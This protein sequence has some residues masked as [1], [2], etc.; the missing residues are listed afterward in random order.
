MEFLS[1]TSSR[2]KFDTDSLT[3]NAEE[4]DKEVEDR[5]RL[6]YGDVPPS[7]TGLVLNGQG[8]K[9][10]YHEPPPGKKY[11]GNAPNIPTMNRRELNS[12]IPP[13]NY[14]LHLITKGAVDHSKI[15][16]DSKVEI[17]QPK[18]I[19]KEHV[20][21]VEKIPQRA[22][23]PKDG[24]DSR[25]QTPGKL[26][27]SEVLTKNEPKG[28]GTTIQKTN[29]APSSN[30]PSPA[31]AT[32][33]SLDSSLPSTGSTP[34]KNS[35]RRTSVSNCHPTDFYSEVVPSN[36]S[37]S[38]SS[39]TTKPKLTSAGS[40][41]NNKFR[42]KENSSNSSSKSSTARNTPAGTP[43]HSCAGGRGVKL[44]RKVLSS[45][46]GN[47][48][49]QTT[50]TGKSK[51]IGAG[52]SNTK[53]A[54]SFQFEF[55]IEDLDDIQEKLLLG[56]KGGKRGSSSGYSA[57]S[58]GIQPSKNSASNSSS[59]TPNVSLNGNLTNNVEKKTGPSLS[60]GVKIG[61]R[62]GRDKNERNRGRKGGWRMDTHGGRRM[63]SLQP[64][65]CTTSGGLSYG[66][67]GRN[68]N[69]KF[70]GGRR[71]S[72]TR[73]LASGEEAL[74]RLLSVKGQDPYSILGVR[75]DSTDETIRRYY[76]KQA[77]LVHPD[78]NLVP[79]AEEAF[80]I[81][82]RA[83]ELVGEPAKRFEYHRQ[84]LEA[85]Q[86]ER[87]FGE[88]GNLLEQLRKKMESVTNTIRCTKC[89]SR[90]NKVRTDR[91]LFA[92]RYCA[93]CRINH[94][95][96]EGDLWAEKKGL[97]GFSRQYYAC[98]DSSIW[99]VNEWASCQKKN[100]KHLQPDSHNVMYRL[101]A[102]GGNNPS[103]SSSKYSNKGQTDPNSFRNNCDNSSFNYS[104]PGDDAN[105]SF[106]DPLE[107]EMD[108]WDTLINNL[109]RS[110]NIAGGGSGSSQHNKNSSNSGS[111]S[112]RV[113]SSGSFNSSSKF[114]GMGTNSNPTTAASA[115][116]GG[117]GS[118]N[119]LGGS[120]NA[121]NVRRR[122]KVKRK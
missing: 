16:Q 122:G 3:A 28:S 13:A 33:R 26:S 24:V 87:V 20:V 4:M 104:S 51:V 17:V 98:M 67:Y 46:V 8:N 5:M 92:A 114:T 2:F 73:I 11:L 39:P 63:L 41:D 108:D 62:N 37:S 89:N 99:E 36:S 65:R 121:A 116:G 38:S 96:R 44:E 42:G 115:A 101:V 86:K 48:N 35:H 102:G 77:V 75:S 34:V 106:E 29:S 83:F 118:A 112:T 111:G 68:S 105:G 119:G 19:G 52:S 120:A 109:F 110:S 27:Y 9:S 100:L 14:N 93:Q 10:L 32:S 88:I 91:P 85:H 30:S 74:K 54:K 43:V 95:A 71:R 69:R 60:N 55:D 57:S 76:K 103:S 25:P 94:A 40:F 64:E 82:A 18:V 72:L 84:L 97:F 7:P 31:P 22:V 107:P 21:M 66:I 81:L 12:M 47:N 6:M 53:N 113:S 61:N 23:T 45:N 49:S 58:T 90:H 79:G 117:L 80:K 15:L 50:G 56:G 1:S 59:T 78:K 70:P